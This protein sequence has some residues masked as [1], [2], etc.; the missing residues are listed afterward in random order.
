M[1]IFMNINRFN[2]KSK[3]INLYSKFYMLFVHNQRKKTKNLTSEYVSESMSTC[4]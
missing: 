1:F 2:A 4:G 3:N